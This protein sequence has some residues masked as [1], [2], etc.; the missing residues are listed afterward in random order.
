MLPLRQTKTMVKVGGQ[1]A[2]TVILRELSFKEKALCSIN[3]TNEKDLKLR[4]AV[5]F[6]HD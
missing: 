2:A 4:W 6:W 3:G 1:T 5:L